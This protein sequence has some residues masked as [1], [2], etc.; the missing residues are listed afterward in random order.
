MRHVC[1]FILSA[2]IVLVAGCSSGQSHFRAGY[3]FSSIDKIAVAD[4]TGSVGSE[5]AK[6][7][8]GDFFVGELLSKG[9][10]PV[11]RSQVQ[12]LLDE[13]DL[14]ASDLTTKQGVARAGEILNVPAI[15]VVNVPNFRDEMSMTAKIIDVEDGSILWMASGTGKAGGW[16]PTIFG[17]AAGAAAGGAVAGE[18]DRTAGAVAGGVIGGA[19][20]KALTPQNAEVAQKIIRDMCKKLPP[21]TVLR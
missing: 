12:N 3:D 4:V 5:A 9:Y 15:L 6:N 20:G 1:P 10:A 16:L 14:Q 11:E 13:Q 2:A 7:Q 17:A 19:A 18:G 8:I 21:R